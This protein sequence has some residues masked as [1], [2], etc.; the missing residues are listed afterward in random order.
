MDR[1]T[2][3]CRRAGVDPAIGLAADLLP[4]NKGVLLLIGRTRDG[5][6]QMWVERAGMALDP[7][8]DPP[9]VEMPAELRKRMGLTGSPVGLDRYAIKELWLIE[10]ATEAA[11]VLERM[12]GSI[13]GA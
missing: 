12:L 10:S 1:L 3:L 2:R 11:E 6:R 9:S 8:T 13:E 7:C 4:L 5:E